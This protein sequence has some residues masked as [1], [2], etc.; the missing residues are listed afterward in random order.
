MINCIEWDVK[1]YSLTDS[2]VMVMIFC[3]AS[4]LFEYTYTLC[5]FADFLCS[6]CPGF[7]ISND[8]IYSSSVWGPNR[9]KGGDFG[10]SEEQVSFLY[11]SVLSVNIVTYIN[12]LWSLMRNLAQLAEFI[13]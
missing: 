2:I 8:P 10:K 5:E 12:F 11:K 6:I 7:P 1:P 13:K 3:A 4:L 9:G